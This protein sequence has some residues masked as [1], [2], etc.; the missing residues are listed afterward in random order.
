MKSRSTRP[1][2]ESPR[3]GR[4]A[5][6]NL[7]GRYE[8]WG[9][10]DSDDGWP[11]EDQRP[12]LPTTIIPHEAKSIL[13]YNRSPDIPFDRSI[14]P[15]QGCEHGCPYC[16]SRP[17]HAYWDMSPGLDFETRI[18]AKTNAAEL[19]RRELSAPSYRP[20]VISIGA[21]TDPYQ[22]AE[23]EL[24]ITRRVVEVLADCEHPFT[25]ITKNALIE[26]DIDLLAPMAEKNLVRAF[27]SVTNL[28]NQLARRIEPRATA[29]LRRIE[30]IERLAAA[31]IPVGVMVAPVIPFLTDS[32]ME[33][34]LERA[35]AAGA[36]MAGYVLLRLPNEVAPLF[37]DW[38][39]Q[40]YPHK[41]QHVMS[42]VQQMRGGKDYQS[43]FGMRQRGQGNFAA[44]TERRFR[45]ACQR[46]G[47]NAELPPMDVA[48]FRPPRPAADRQLDLL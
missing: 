25:V 16:Y 35:R 18:I 27:V 30:A 34:V 19:L 41:A 43:G 21:S 38:L 45:L 48:R 10:E 39:A 23:R 28:D 3:K 36:V 1:P 5:T 42:L 4:G 29:P 26:R 22:P 7:Q 12:A 2:T 20:D 33:E 24:N 46:L 8:R 14:N 11:Q 47:F 31:G 6:F 9:R 40:H 44:L 32:F 15:Y 37:R 13:T 17:T